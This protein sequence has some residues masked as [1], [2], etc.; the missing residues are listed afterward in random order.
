MR[1]IISF[2]LCTLLFLGLHAGLY[3]QATTGAV[4]GTVR[5]AAGAPM[6][7]VRIELENVATGA[8]MVMMTDQTGRYRFDNVPAGRYRVV[9]QHAQMAAAPSPE[10]SVGMNQLHTMNVTIAVGPVTDAITAVEEPPVEETTANIQTY[11]TTRPVQYLPQSNQ[12]DQNGSAYGALNL[13][14]LS[15]GITTGGIGEARGPAVSGIRPIN[16]NF[17]VD[18]VANNN[19]A[20]PGPLNYVSNEA[21]NDFV[22]LQN[23][24]RPVTGQSTGGQFA[25]IIRSGTNQFHGQLYNYFQNRMMNAREPQLAASGFDSLPRYDQNRLG[26]AAGFP[27][28]PNSLFFFGNFEYIP[29]GVTSYQPGLPQVPTA[30]GLALLAGIPGVSPTTLSILEGIPTGA[31]TGQTA[32]VGGVGIPLGFADTGVP[33]FQNKYMATGAVDWNPTFRDQLRG[34]Y[35]QNVISGGTRL[36]GT[37]QNFPSPDFTT[38]LANIS[39][40]RTFGA[41]AT[42]E[43]RF[44]YNRLNSNVFNSPWGLNPGLQ[45]IPGTGLFPGLA[46]VPNLNIL[47]TNFATGQQWPWP[48]RSR[49]NTY[50]I[51]DAFGF[52]AGAHDF[53][54]GFDGRRYIGWQQGFPEFLGNYGYSSLERFAFDLSPDIVSQQRFGANYIPINQ[55]LITAYAQ[56]TWRVLPNLLID[57]GFRYQFA[58]VP[59][60]WQQQD[61]FVG[62]GVPGVLDIGSPQAQ[63]NAVGT[64]AGFAWSPFARRQTVFRGGFGLMY[65]TLYQQLLVQPWFPNQSTLAVGDL[66]TPTPGFLAGGGLAPTVIPG[67]GLTPEQQRA[68]FSTFIPQNPRLPYAMLW[69]ASLQHTFW[70]GFTGE[71]RYLGSRGVRQPV[72][73]QVGA[74]PVTAAQSLPMFLTNPGQAFL[75]T[76]PLTLGTLQGNIAA[77]PIQAAGFTSPINTFNFDGNS[78]YH[79]L[80]LVANQRFVGGFQMLANWTWSHLID[81]STGTQ[82]DTVFGRQR[83]TSLF[84]RR[85]RVNVTGLFD[86]APLMPNSGFLTRLFADFT[87]GGS[88]IYESPQFL[89]A[90]GALP[91]FGLGGFAEGTGTIFNP[92]GIGGVATGVNPL[93]NTAGD[94]VAY[95]AINPGAQII[96]GGLGMFAPFGRNA[97]ALQRTSQVALTALKRFNVADRFGFEIRG[98]AYNL[99]N[100]SNFTGGPINNIDFRSPSRV[101]GLF[102]AASPGFGD[103]VQFLSANPRLMQVTLRIIF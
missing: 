18:G 6:P 16:N 46:G 14:L 3:G 4:Q 35:V 88:Y 31:A 50:Y 56:D 42:N 78:I 102:G 49:N 26:G 90:I 94:I 68:G 21:T 40:Y 97:F 37:T 41:T 89:P 76:L 2:T 100:T 36:G 43:L 83:N 28:I 93:F 103:D 15:E 79:G 69:N 19:V 1:Q 23:Q 65:D 17:H 75:D 82:F 32:F 11:F 74:T 34:R 55:Y 58:T 27:I 87:L 5:D 39:Y 53:R 60:G 81:D 62:I 33:A 59:Q 92:E 71:A 44:G 25:N 80:A 84:D 30:E 22:L 73:G 10:F 64:Q 12:V 24:P 13:S 9:T 63:R 52:R 66:V 70:R 54:V 96:G 98:D 29:L 99:T 95:Q 51:A 45:N 72:L 77:S 57:L 61:Q 86:L 8:R 67:P 7:N 38:L 48:E 91:G 20:F 85:H 101:P 47:E